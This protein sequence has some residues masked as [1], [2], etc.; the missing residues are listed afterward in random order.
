MIPLEERLR[1]DP[2][3]ANEEDGELATVDGDVLMMLTLAPLVKEATLE[4]LMAAASSNRRLISPK[5]SLFAESTL[6]G[7]PP[8]LAGL[9]A[10]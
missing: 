8:P 3:A 2:L 4:E 7:P 9:S 6:G 5:D 1:I 10:A